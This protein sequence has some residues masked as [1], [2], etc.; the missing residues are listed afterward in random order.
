[1]ASGKRMSRIQ[2]FAALALLATAMIGGAC[3]VDETLLPNEPPETTLFLG[4]G[5]LSPT[6]YRQ[7]LSWHGEDPDGEVARYE[8]RWVYDPASGE[9]DSS[10]VGTVEPFVTNTRDTFFLPV[11]GTVMDPLTHRFEIRAVDGEGARDPE[12]AVQS[13]PVYNTAP[14]IWAVTSSGDTTS[15]LTLPGNILPVLTLR[16]KVA[17]PDNPASDPEEAL[18]FIEEIRFWFEDP[19][20]YLSIQGTDSMLTLVPEDFGDLV[21]QEREFHLQAFDRGG[22]GSNVLSASAFVRDVQAARVLLMDSAAAASAPNTGFV[23]PFWKQEFPDLLQPEEL[24][25]HDIAAD[26][27][28]GDPVNLH[29]IFS[30]FEAVLW[31]NGADGAP[32]GFSNDPSPEFTEAEDALREY[33]EAGGHALLCG[34]NLIGA[35]RG[36]HPGGSFSVDFENEVLLLDSLYVHSTG[37]PPG[38]DT[39]NYWVLAN[40]GP[41]LFPGFE[42]AGTDTLLLPFGGSLK[43]VDRMALNDEAQTE[44][45]IEELYRLDGDDTYPSSLVDGAVGVRRRFD[46]GGEIVLLTFPI[47][48]VE[49]NDNVLEQVQ[50]FLQ[51]FGVLR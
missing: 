48:L 34:Y 45:L 10:W 12:P 5:D 38:S 39:T 3:S 25:I 18:A 43:G 6:H 36:E 29:A 1:M 14:R 26:G 37:V 50:G 41:K 19:E 9:T 8:Y 2:I 11:P 30:L 21:G 13:F 32:I 42:Q 15:T 27:P 23:E 4:E 20:S 22:A 17:D 28:L 49:G 24:M 33:A 7:I 31:Y 44:G 51:E 35:S 47:S 40:T 16:F 46:S